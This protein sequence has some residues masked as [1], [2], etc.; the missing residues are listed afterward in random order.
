MSS[1]N[2]VY[3]E[4]QLYSYPHLCVAMYT[5]RVFFYWFRLKSSKFGTPYLELLRLN[6]SFSQLGGTSSILLNHGLY[7]GV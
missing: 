4:E 5:L 2:V 1:S 3:G 6:Q 7:E